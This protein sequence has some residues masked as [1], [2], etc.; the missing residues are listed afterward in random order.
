MEKWYQ[1]Y[2]GGFHLQRG[3]CIWRCQHL[4]LVF[5]CTEDPLQR[6]KVPTDCCWWCVR[7]QSDKEKFCQRP[8]WGDAVGN[9]LQ[10]FT[11]QTNAFVPRS[12]PIQS[13]YVR[14]HLRSQRVQIWRYR[15]QPRGK[16]WCMLYN[17]LWALQVGLQVSWSHVKDNKQ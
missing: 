14:K 8:V 3:W 7:F 1:G 10:N 15:H 17:S 13:Y 9:D 4:T 11:F 12:Q 6:W 2:Y 5:R 16:A